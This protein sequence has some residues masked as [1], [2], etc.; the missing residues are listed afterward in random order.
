[1]KDE[2]FGNIGKCCADAGIS[3]LISAGI[4]AI[5]IFLVGAVVYAADDPGKFVTAAAVAVAAISFL[6]AGVIGAKKGGGFLTG[7]LAGAVLLAVF[8]LL[9]V[10]FD[11]ENVVP[12]S[13]F[14]YSLVS[15]ALELLLSAAGAFFASKRETKRKK[16]PAPRV[17]K[18]KHK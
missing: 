11:G 7:F 16:H 3:A 1:M 15:R 5:L 12:Y 18:I 17:P 13:D 6:A 14:P 8:L 2:H 9:S 4:A 10:F